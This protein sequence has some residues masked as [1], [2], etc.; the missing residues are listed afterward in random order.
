MSW[1]EVKELAQTGKS[2][3]ENLSAIALSGGTDIF[4]F[5]SAY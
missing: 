2:L 5:Y 1:G 3:V 4:A